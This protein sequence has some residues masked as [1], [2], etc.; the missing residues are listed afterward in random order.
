MKSK[1]SEFWLLAAADK[2]T[3][4]NQNHTFVIKFP[5]KQDTGM[6]L[7]IQAY[8]YVTIRF[9]SVIQREMVFL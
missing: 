3:K 9:R 2:N 7:G 4:S 1:L 5:T 8:I 6:K